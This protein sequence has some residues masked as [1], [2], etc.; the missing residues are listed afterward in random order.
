MCTVAADSRTFR[1]LCSRHGLSVTEGEMSSRM[2]LM[3][4]G[5]MSTSQRSPGA[6][7]TGGCQ[8]NPPAYCPDA[9]VSRAMMAVFIL[10]SLSQSP[11]PTC[12]GIFG[13]AN[14]ATVGNTFCRFI[15]KFAELGITGGCG[16]G[17]F[18]PNSPVTRGQMSVFIETA[19]GHTSSTCTGQFSDVPVGHPFC[20]FIEHLA[21]MGLQA[22]VEEGDIVPMTR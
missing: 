13:D 12:T 16:T 11:A 14:A 2:F 15:E 1:I 7:I 18:C 22:A 21:A 9:N 17:V 4:T 5:R 6:G 3:G 20:R 8:E 10:T 19:L